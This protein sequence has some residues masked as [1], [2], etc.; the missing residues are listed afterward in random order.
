MNLPIRNHTS[1]PLTLFIEPFCD[2]YQI[3][4]EGEAIVILEDGQPHSLDLHPDN[5][6]SLWDEGQTAAVV[7]I[8]S[9]KQNA[10][11]DALSFAS[12][13]LYVQGQAAAEDLQDAIEGEEKAVGYLAAR[14]G[15]YRAFRA[16]FR[17]K[18]LES[19]PDSALLPKWPGNPTLAGAYR[20]GGVAAFFN[21]R[22]R[23]DPSL[24][25]LG[26]APFDT[27]TAHQKFKDADAAVA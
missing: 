13:W 5:F 17:E 21:Y 10:V 27:D 26:K 9:K 12:I 2:E 23:L 19:D 8:V 22:V 16:G 14:F 20:A 7:E 25:E 1:T 6:V 18:A 24:I 11:V 3:P 4:P 15:A